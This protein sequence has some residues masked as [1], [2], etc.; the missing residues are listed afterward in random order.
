MSPE[1]SSPKAAN[2]KNLLS[3][4]SSSSAQKKCKIDQADPEISAGKGKFEEDELENTKASS[5]TFTK[6]NAKAIASQFVRA[7]DLEKTKLSEHGVYP[8]KKKSGAPDTDFTEKEKALF[9]SLRDS[10]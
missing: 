5:P 2:M 7:G 8:Q 10:I 1:I 4:A 3:A 6:E 9:R